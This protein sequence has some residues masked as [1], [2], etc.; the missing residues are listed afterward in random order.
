MWEDTALSRS[1]NGGTLAVREL[2]SVY[3]FFPSATPG[4]TVSELPVYTADGEEHEEIEGEEDHRDEEDEE[5]DHGDEEDDHGDEEDDHG[6][7]E[8]DHG[9]EHAGEGTLT[10]HHFEPEDPIKQ[11]ALGK[12]GRLQ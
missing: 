11:V 9:D 3:N 5:D 12:T 7:E 2:V 1:P 8:D 4:L 6:D 10:E